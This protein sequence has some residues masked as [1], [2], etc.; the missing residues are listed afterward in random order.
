MH[1]CNINLKCD[2]VYM[3]VVCDVLIVISDKH[4]DSSYI[5]AISLPQCK[6]Y[7]ITEDLREKERELI[8][9]CDKHTFVEK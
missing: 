8:K 2:V 5:S 9:L 1:D 6:Y 7:R 3:H 4:I